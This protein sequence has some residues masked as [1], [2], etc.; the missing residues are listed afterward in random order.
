MLSVTLMQLFSIVSITIPGTLPT[1]GSYGFHEIEVYPINQ[2]PRSRVI[3]VT[4]DSQVS[5]IVPKI[6]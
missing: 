5:P 3:T 6:V 1:H 4:I 2:K